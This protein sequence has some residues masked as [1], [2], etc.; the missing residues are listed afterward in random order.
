MLDL[1]TRLRQPAEYRQYEVGQHVI[2]LPGDHNLPPFQGAHR[3]YDR[4]LPV[5]CSQLPPVGVIVDVGANVGDTIAAIIQTCTNQ[6]IAIEG[7]LPYFEILRGNLA[8]VDLDRR[9]TAIH[10]LVGSGVQIGSL[11]ADGGTATFHNRGSARM[12][13]LDDVLANWLDQVVL[14]K[15]DTDGWDADVISSGMAM[16][17]ASRPMLFWEGGTSGAIA[18]ESMYEKLAAAEYDLFWIFDNFGN[19]MLCECGIE[20]LKYVDRYV[21]S[22]YNHSCTRTIYYV[23][24]LASTSKTAAEARSAIAKYRREFIEI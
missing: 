8:V 11:V 22:Q 4:F 10:T 21:A 7:Y 12:Q 13:S 1:K 16:I 23:D 18:F 3:L 6:I 17:K 24:V 19:L 9:V 2:T 14:L 15:V 5:L 20:E